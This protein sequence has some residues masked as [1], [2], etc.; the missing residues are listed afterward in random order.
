MITSISLSS[1]SIEWD[2]N[3]TT[4]RVYYDRNIYLM[5]MFEVSRFGQ[6]RTT[7]N[8]LLFNESLMNFYRLDGLL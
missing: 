6:Y 1:P 4:D 5:A 2:L 7:N 3:F 8:L